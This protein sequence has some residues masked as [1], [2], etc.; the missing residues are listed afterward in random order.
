MEDFRV[1]QYMK[2]PACW[3]CPPILLHNTETTMA[4]AANIPM[5][6]LTLLNDIN[7]NKI[8]PKLA[9][10]RPKACNACEKISEI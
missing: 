10:H 8:T 3:R 7:L 2:L 9:L 4:T 5:P 6:A 1:R